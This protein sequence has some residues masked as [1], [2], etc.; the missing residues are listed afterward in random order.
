MAGIISK[1]VAEGEIRTD[2]CSEVLVSFLLGMLRTQ[3]R[4]LADAP[5]AMRQLEVLL[6]LLSRCSESHSKGRG[7]QRNRK[8]LA[9]CRPHGRQTFFSEMPDEST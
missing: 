3:A 7:R 5:Q 1:G 9:F 4:D 8:R 6:D 2:I